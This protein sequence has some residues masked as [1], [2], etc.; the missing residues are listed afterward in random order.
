M[1]KNAWL[2]PDA[3]I[4]ANPQGCRT[5]SVP[6]DL[7]YL[8]TGCLE[9]L[10]ESENWEVFGTATP[11]EMA[12][13]FRDV[14][15]EHVDSGCGMKWLDDTYTLFSGTYE[16]YS[17]FDLAFQRSSLPAEMQNATGLRIRMKATTPSNIERT[18][19]AEHPI[20]GFIYDWMKLFHQNKEH[21]FSITTGIEEGV[22]FKINEA[23]GNEFF[24]EAKIVGWW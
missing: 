20:T 3:S 6:G 11:D 23:V 15:D 7:F 14:I 2:T 5:I 18:I 9:L 12:Q 21:R 8:V 1:S 10:A 17:G 13:Y 22:K 4:L 24:W 16:M 19:T